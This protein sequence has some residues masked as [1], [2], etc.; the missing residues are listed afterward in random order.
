VKSLHHKTLAV[1]IFTVLG[2]LFSPPITPI[3][4]RVM[5]TSSLSFS[6]YEWNVKTTSGSL[7]GPGPNYFN[8]S[9]E[10]VWVDASGYLHLRI[11][12]DSI[13]EI[14]YCA[15]VY[16]IDSFGYGTY[17]FTLAPGFEDLDKNVVLGLF[18]YLDDFNEI[19]IEFARWG[20]ENASNGQFVLQPSWKPNHK[21]RFEFDP[22]GF[23]SNHSF[24]WCKNSIDFSSNNGKL[25]RYSWQFFGLGVPKPSIEKARM[26][27]WL[28][29]GLVPSNGF[30]S[31]VVVK[32][33]EFMPSECTNYPLLFWWIL[34]I[35]VIGLSVVIFSASLFI[36]WKRK[37]IRL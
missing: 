6:G 22:Q 11:T 10:N 33:F 35:S 31:E 18:T 21:E 9:N 7:G 17:T 8:D 3:N 37:T 13:N 28:M 34:I 14:W 1:C 27:L 23:D 16:S 4:P 26:N 2:G 20:D 5:A 29:Q 12:Y 36:W 25:E 30:E 32:S 24:T 19:D 15:E